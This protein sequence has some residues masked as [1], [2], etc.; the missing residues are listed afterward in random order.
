MPPIEVAAARAVQMLQDA[1]HPAFTSSERRA[2]RN[3]VRLAL[4][5]YG[6]DS[7]LDYLQLLA[8]VEAL[9][10]FRKAVA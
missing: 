2:R 1:L 7:P 5:A 4:A 6:I 3:D 9:C 8:F 10:G